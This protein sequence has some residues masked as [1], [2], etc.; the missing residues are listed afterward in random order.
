MLLGCEPNQWPAPNDVLGEIKI[1]HREKSF[2]NVYCQPGCTDLPLEN[3]Q[4]NKMFQ[5]LLAIRLKIKSLNAM[6]HM[7]FV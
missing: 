5:Y 3:E 7:V 1:F 2:D 6:R 4:R